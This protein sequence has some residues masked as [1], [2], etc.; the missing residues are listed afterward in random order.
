MACLDFRPKWYATLINC[1]KSIKYFL[2]KV[3]QTHRCTILLYV[4]IHR[5]SFCYPLAISLL[6]K[7]LY[8]SQPSQ[9]IFFAYKALFSTLSAEQFWSLQTYSQFKWISALNANYCLVDYRTHYNMYCFI[10]STFIVAQFAVLIC[11]LFLTR[12]I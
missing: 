5:Q 3:V 1:L 11:K 8:F 6:S 4:L 12:Y 2:L 7:R 10:K 9:Y